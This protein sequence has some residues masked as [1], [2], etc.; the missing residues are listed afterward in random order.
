M[1]NG[2][3]VDVDYGPAMAPR[4]RPLPRAR[5][6]LRGLW[7]AP[8]LVHTCILGLLLAA[9]LPFVGTNA[10]FSADE[11]AAMIQA[12]QLARGD[13]WLT[14]YAFAA[15]DS[16]AEAFPLDNAD[17]GRDGAAAYAKHPLYPVLLA[18]SDRV[19]GTPAMFI[20]SIVGTM[21]AA[22]FAALLAMRW[23]PAV[24]RPTLW[25]V[26]VGSPLL[27]DSFLVIAHTLGAAAATVAVW[28]ALRC[29]ERRSVGVFVGMITSVFVACALRTEAILFA[30]AL[31]VALFVVGRTR[32][33][34]N[35][36]L[37]SAAVV[38]TATVVKLAEPHVVRGLL[39]TPTVSP[40]S[41]GVPSHGFVSDRI[42]S[43]ITTWLSPGYGVL[44]GGAL[45]A[46]VLGVVVIVGAALV[47]NRPDDDGPINLL[48]SFAI[49]ISAFTLIIGTETIPGLVF[50]A[51]LL[52]GGLVVIR[53]EDLLDLTPRVLLV[54][55]A[56]FSAAV[57]ATQ[58]S[59]GGSGEW[60]GRY[61][62]LGLPILCPVVLASMRATGLRLHRAP[63]R[64]ALGACVAVVVSLGLVGIYD[65]RSIHLRTNDIVEA[66]QAVSASTSPG[67]GG[68]PIVMTYD[69]VLPRASWRVFG[70]RRYLMPPENQAAKYLVRLRRAGIRE[71]MFATRDPRVRLEQL[72]PAYRV[73]RVQTL[74]LGT[75][76]R[77]AVLRAAG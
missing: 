56:L 31:A 28:C 26:G 62:A 57:L 41:A 16:K 51:P 48:S 37:L 4:Q 3:D 10:I 14:P 39:G 33:K 2:S 74:G 9:L 1:L 17:A 12:K 45:S 71:L 72:G 6:V 30:F 23:N 54:T 44:R 21:I 67:D 43:F 15:I 61:F 73:V 34:A 46:L 52:V 32:G 25:L 50:A 76:W 58:Y 5:R 20:L 65:L 53:R 60:G 18:A 40:V 36:T 69:G 38:M 77:F 42:Q 11:G 63:R 29:L 19:G 64:L 59:R 55:W 22:L 35:A 8:L 66:A 27:Y 13:G 24:A 75:S 70:S 49:V 47:R 7:E 68:K